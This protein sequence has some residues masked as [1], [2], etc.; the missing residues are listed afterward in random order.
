MKSRTTGTA[1]HARIIERR[2]VPNN[3]YVDPARPTDTT[4]QAKWHAATGRPS[5][6]LHLEIMLRHRHSGNPVMPCG[7]Q[8]AACTA[9]QLLHFAMDLD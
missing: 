6:D 3:V 9:Q 2:P 7:Q 5:A 8:Y 1:D 4:E